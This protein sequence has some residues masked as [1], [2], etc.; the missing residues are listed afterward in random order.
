MLSKRVINK[1]VSV[2][3]KSLA[4]ARTYSTDNK[5]VS[6]DNQLDLMNREHV[7]SYNRTRDYYSALDLVQHG[8]NSEIKKNFNDFGDDNRDPESYDC[9]GTINLSCTMQTNVPYPFKTN[10]H[11]KP[12]HCNMPAGNV[13]KLD[14]HLSSHR[15]SI[16]DYQADNH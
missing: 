3:C 4:S 8:E 2:T 11:T 9:R 15:V 12:A 10:G 13:S 6:A 1:I 7:F 5:Y 16:L 14:K